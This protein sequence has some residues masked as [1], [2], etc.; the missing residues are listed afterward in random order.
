[1]SIDSVVQEPTWRQEGDTSIM[2]NNPVTNT[3]K[4]RQATLY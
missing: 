1:M 4:R 2:L 3:N